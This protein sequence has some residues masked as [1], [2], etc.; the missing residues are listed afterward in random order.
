MQEFL[1]GLAVSSMRITCKRSRKLPANVRLCGQPRREML[2]LSSSQ[3]DRSGQWSRVEFSPQA[4]GV[5]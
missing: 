3:F 1:E 2:K 5:P 4:P